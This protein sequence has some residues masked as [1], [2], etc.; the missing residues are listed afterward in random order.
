MGAKLLPVRSVASSE[1]KKLFVRDVSVILNTKNFYGSKKLLLWNVMHDANNRH[2]RFG[3]PR[4][5][6]L[7][8]IFP[9]VKTWSD[10]IDDDVLTDNSSEQKVLEDGWSLL[11]TKLDSQKHALYTKFKKLPSAENVVSIIIF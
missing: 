1:S 10:I 4:Q 8:E 7:H 6:S 5:S 2:Y 9:Y 3:F 11:V